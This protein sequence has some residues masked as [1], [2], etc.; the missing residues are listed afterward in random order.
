MGLPF[1]KNNIAFKLIIK[2]VNAGRCQLMHY[3]RF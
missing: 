2:L 1:Y 3:I